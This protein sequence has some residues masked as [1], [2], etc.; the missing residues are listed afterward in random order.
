MTM[1]PTKLFQFL[2]GALRGAYGTEELRSRKF[3]IMVS[4]QLGHDLLRRLCLPD[5]DVLVKD[6]S[7]VNYPK[8]F[9]VCGYVGTYGG[10]ERDVI[11]DTLAGEVV[12]KGKSVSFSFIGDDA[13]TQGI[14]EF[15][16]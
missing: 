3:L 1:C 11:I 16:L 6:C 4:S 14:H 7:M 10:E 5:V 8:L 2:R 15:Y 9:S 12:L 13:Y